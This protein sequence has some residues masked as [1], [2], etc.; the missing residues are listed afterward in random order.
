M[1]AYAASF[2][3]RVISSDGRIIN[4]LLTAKS[5]VAPLKTISVPRLKLCAALLLAQLIRFVRSSLLAPDIDY[6]C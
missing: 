3:L 4:T 5:K 2:Y 6:W 1:K